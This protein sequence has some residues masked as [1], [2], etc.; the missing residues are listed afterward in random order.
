MV[1]VFLRLRSY[2]Q[3]TRDWF[4]VVVVVVVVV[5]VVVVVVVCRFL[6]KRKDIGL[7][8]KHTPPKHR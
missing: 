5:A 1:S 2:A 4:V 7:S 6:K 8:S 3:P